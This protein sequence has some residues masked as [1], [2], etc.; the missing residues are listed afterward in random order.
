MCLATSQ[1]P[2]LRSVMGGGGGGG[3]QDGSGCGLADQ[4]FLNLFDSPGF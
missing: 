2:L 3:G 1:D 4:E